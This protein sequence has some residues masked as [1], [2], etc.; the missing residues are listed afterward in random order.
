MTRV[1]P[2]RGQ[3][4]RETRCINAKQL[5]WFIAITTCA[6][7]FLLPP[8]F[9]LLLRPETVP[10]AT[11]PCGECTLPLRQWRTCMQ[12]INRPFDPFFN[13]RQ[14]E[15]RV[16]GFIFV[17]KLN[18]SNRFFTRPIRQNRRGIERI[19]ISDRGY[20]FAVTA[21]SPAHKKRLR[22][23]RFDATEIWLTERVCRKFCFRFFNLEHNPSEK[24]CH[25]PERH[26][27]SRRSAH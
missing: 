11:R 3:T 22:G 14:C 2:I 15:F 19:F 26:P 21:V 12:F 4:R 16:E 13:T 1:P 25:F 8:C 5:A 20:H 27:R 10:H 23:L 17:R 18:R 9:S 6:C 24:P 7:Y